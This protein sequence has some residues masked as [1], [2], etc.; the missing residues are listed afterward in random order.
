MKFGKNIK[1]L[2][3]FNKLSQEELA[4]KVDVARQSISKWERD[5]GYPAWDKIPA[6]CSIFQCN[7][8]DL[9]SDEELGKIM[10]LENLKEKPIKI[11]GIDTL[12]MISKMEAMGV[13]AYIIDRIPK[14]S[15][16]HFIDT[17]EDYYISKF[18]GMERIKNILKDWDLN[19][20]KTIIIDL[21]KRFEENDIIIHI[22]DVIELVELI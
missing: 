12:E 7:H 1:K 3:E 5:E 19:A 16:E 11:E 15:F 6:L 21:L 9:L 14:N 18:D 4:D 20:R 8:Y 10:D 22:S 2:R 17:L 13:D